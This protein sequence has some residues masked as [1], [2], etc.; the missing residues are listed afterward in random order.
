MLSQFLSLSMGLFLSASAQA[1]T[2]T[3]PLSSGQT[4]A[5]LCVYQPD[6]LV[7]PT[8]TSVVICGSDKTDAL[9]KTLL[10]DLYKTGCVGFG[11]KCK[12]SPLTPDDLTKAFEHIQANA[13]APASTRSARKSWACSLWMSPANCARPPN[14]SP[15]LG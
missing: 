12:Q 13:S 10:S 2:K 14:L 5:T 9:E 3:V 1:Q 8:G 6:P 11:L 15:S 4:G 7:R